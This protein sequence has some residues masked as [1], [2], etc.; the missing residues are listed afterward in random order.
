MSTNKLIYNSIN[1][2]IDILYCINFEIVLM[3][4]ELPKS[5]YVYLIILLNNWQAITRYKT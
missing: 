5:V 1:E 3:Y 2:K 4:K